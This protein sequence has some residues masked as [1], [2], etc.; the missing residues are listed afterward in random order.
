MLTEFVPL[1]R[2]LGVSVFH[3]AAC[4]SELALWWER[5]G[6]EL[7]KVLTVATDERAPA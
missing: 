2:R 7:R 4:A 3:A 1:A 6:G 5:T